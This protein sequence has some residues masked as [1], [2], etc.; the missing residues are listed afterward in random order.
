MRS[1]P[2]AGDDKAPLARFRVDPVPV[3]EHAVR[4]R[5]AWP[6]CRP[7]HVDRNEHA[8][9]VCRCRCSKGASPTGPRNGRRS[10]TA[11]VRSS[12]AP[13]RFAASRS[14]ASDRRSNSPASALRCVVSGD[15]KRT[16]GRLLSIASRDDLGEDV[17]DEGQLG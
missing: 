13:G 14:Q 9:V 5:V 8:R 4:S 10:L 1:L 15:I 12:L 6:H 3:V 2:V 17:A 7:G 11:A 16:A